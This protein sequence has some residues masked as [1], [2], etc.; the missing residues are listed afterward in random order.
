MKSGPVE[1]EALEALRLRE[2]DLWTS[3]TRFD[4]EF[5]STMS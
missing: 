1:G 3:E 5:V 4:N 2:E